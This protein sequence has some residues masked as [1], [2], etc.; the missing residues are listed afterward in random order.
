MYP[1][2]AATLVLDRGTPV[3]VRRATATG[4]PDWTATV[5]AVI[6]QGTPE[7]FAA[8]RHVIGH[9]LTMAALDPG[10]TGFPAPPKAGDLVTFFGQTHIII[11][12]ERRPIGA[13]DAL[14][15]ATT[16]TR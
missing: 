4:S 15:I 14:W 10:W 9:T 1:D 7:E 2:G 3:T 16:R 6:R 5:K 8:D 11:G 13:D 12:V